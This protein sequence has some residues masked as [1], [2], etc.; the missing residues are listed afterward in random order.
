MS[1]CNR[2]GYY[3]KSGANKLWQ[4]KRG[5][6]PGKR[7]IWESPMGGVLEGGVSAIVGKLG[8]VCEE[9]YCK[10]ILTKN[11]MVHEIIT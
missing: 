4:E 11:T 5:P 3:G 6:K 2:F 1:V 7:Q 10:G 9:V 8:S